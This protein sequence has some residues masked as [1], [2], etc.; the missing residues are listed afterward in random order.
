MLQDHRD[1]SSCFGR[2]RL[3]SRRRSLLRRPDCDRGSG[4]NG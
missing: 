4:R 2:P 3:R 1:G